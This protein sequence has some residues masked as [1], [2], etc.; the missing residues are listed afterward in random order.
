[1]T[2]TA[3]EAGGN[4][5]PTAADLRVLQ[6]LASEPTMK[7]VAVKLGRSP[8][9]TRRLVHE[10]VDRVGAPHARAALALA[11]QRGWVTVEMRANG[12]HSPE[13]SAARNRSTVSLSGAG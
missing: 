10:V 11:G 13:P 12:R 5:V 1:M 2:K 8:R 7:A 9:H 4:P 3:H 6:A